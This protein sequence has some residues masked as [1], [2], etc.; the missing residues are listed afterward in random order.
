MKK[1]FVIALLFVL[2]GQLIRARGQTIANSKES[3]PLDSAAKVAHLQKNIEKL[4]ND[5]KN[6]SNDGKSPATIHFLI[7]MDEAGLKRYS[8]AVKEFSTAIRLDPEMKQVYLSRGLAQDMLGNYELAISDYKTCLVVFKDNPKML[9]RL[10]LSIGKLQ[11]MLKNFDDAVE[12]ES[13]AITLAPFY[14]E[15]YLYRGYG[16]MFL[17]KYDLAILD[18]TTAMGGYLNNDKILAGIFYTR[19]EAKR[20]SKRYKDAINDYA[21]A[22]RL[23]PTNKLAYWNLAASYNNNGDYQLA[24]EY[25]TKAIDFYKGDNKNLSR[26][27]DDRALMEMAEQKLLQAIKDDS[28]AIYYD[29]KFAPAYWNRANAYAQ[30]ADFQ[31]SADAY[32]QTMNFYQ[33]NKRALAQLF[34]NVADM[35]YFLSD[36]EKV[37]DYTTSSINLNPK[38]WEPYLNRGRAYLKKN[39]KELAMSD[40]SKVLE[41]DTTKTSFAYAFALFYTGNPDEAIDVMQKNVIATTNDPVLMSHYYNIACLYSLINKHDEANIYLRKCIDGGYPKKY[42]LADPDLENIRNTQ[43]YKDMTK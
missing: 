12:F 4:T 23:N 38:Q 40:F 43:E 16:H 6:V 22:I 14:S 20:Y 19:G 1:I 5:L 33:L 3:L 28:L 9:A 11:G 21:E 30:N 29:D 34:N 39:S 17:G 18:L 2:M 32:I 10:Y 24:D 15:A 27:Y 42:A 25:Y 36:Y 8:E 31:L 26:L 7:G 35:E 41:L 37:I 13:K